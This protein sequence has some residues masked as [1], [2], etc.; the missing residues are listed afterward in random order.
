MPDSAIGVDLGRTDLR[1][2]AIAEHGN[3]IGGLKSRVSLERRLLDSS[4]A[5][6]KA[7]MPHLRRPDQPSIR[8][9]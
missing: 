8:T 6:L 2:A 4:A 1:I 7:V 3:L 5:A 9:Q